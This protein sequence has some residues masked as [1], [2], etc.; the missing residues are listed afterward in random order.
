MSNRSPAR[1]PNAPA[2]RVSP[3][4]RIPAPRGE[5]DT[6]WAMVCFHATKTA[7]G[8]GGHDDRRVELAWRSDT[9]HGQALVRISALARAGRGHGYAQAR[10]CAYVPG[11]LPCDL[12]LR[13]TPDGSEDP[14]LLEQAD[15]LVGRIPLSPPAAR[16]RARDLLE[17]H[18]GCLVAVVPDLNAG[19]VVGLRDGSGGVRYLW[20]EPCA[21]GD[22]VP[23]RILGS[24]LHAWIAAGE[25]PHTLRS[26]RPE[27]RR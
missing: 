17:R 12:H 8:P 6:A 22:Y 9:G 20:P 26:V 14:V 13:T 18:P 2:P 27:P 24:V 25:S 3:V 19:C 1:G 10:P 16:R 4:I 11:G 7:D 23:P 21:S 5:P 15:V